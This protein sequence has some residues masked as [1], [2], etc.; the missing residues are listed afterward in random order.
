MRKEK[1]NYGFPHAKTARV[2][3]WTRMRKR[4]TDGRMNAADDGFCE[5]QA[6]GGQPGSRSITDTVYEGFRKNALETRR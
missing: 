4:E 2:R 1:R 3:G 5:F 6:M